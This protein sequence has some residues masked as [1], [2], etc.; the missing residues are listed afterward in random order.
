LSDV[1][2]SAALGR[3]QASIAVP[4]YSENNGTL[5]GLW[6]G[7]LNLTTFSES[8]QSLNLTN[9]NNNDG[10]RIVIADQQGQKIA[11]SSSQSLLSSISFNESFADLQS[12]KNAINGESGTITET[13]SGTLTAVSYHPAKAFSNVGTVLFMQPHGDDGDML[14]GNTIVTQN[15]LVIPN[16]Q[17]E[18][19]MV[20]DP[21]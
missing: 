6:A 4:M 12:F 3:P 20:K 21:D 1:I 14:S 18:L 13:I 16:E 9:N 10:E 11:D 7:G 8:L 5:V 2:I 17:E 15:D 19:V